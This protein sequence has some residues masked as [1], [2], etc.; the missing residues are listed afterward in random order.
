[1]KLNYISNNWIKFCAINLC[2]LLSVSVAHATPAWN[3]IGNLSQNPGL[4]DTDK[5][6]YRILATDPFGFDNIFNVTDIRVFKDA[7][8]TY[9]HRLRFNL[10]SGSVY[11]LDW[12]KAFL[13]S[14]AY[15][16]YSL[17]L[18]GPERAFEPALYLD[19]RRPSKVQGAVD[20]SFAYKFF[21][22][23]AGGKMYSTS[24]SLYTDKFVLQTSCEIVRATQIVGPPTIGTVSPF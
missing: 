9:S 6:N 14:T 20:I 21:N 22:Q 16:T 1:M 8:G 2:C 18:R 17:H 11:T 10:D 4:L 3:T 19:V 24:Y 12:I 23:A 13:S 15:S 5:C 7:T